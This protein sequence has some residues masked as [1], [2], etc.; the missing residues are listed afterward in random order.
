MPTT[1]EQA[2]CNALATWLRAQTALAD[3]EFLSHWPDDEGR[4]QPKTIAILRAGEPDREP[5][6]PVELSSENI[7]DALSARIVVA[8]PEDLP[9]AITALNTCRSSYEAHRVSTAAHQA[10]DTT[11]I[12]AAPAASN[13]S[14]AITLANELRSDI[15]LHEADATSH[16]NAD[17]RNRITAAAASDLA[18]LLTLTAAIVR[19]L[20]SHY[21]ARIFLWRVEALVQPVQMDVWATYEAVRDE[22]LAAL[23]PALHARARDTAPSLFPGPGLGG[24]D[25]VRFDLLLELGDGWTGCGATARFDRPVIADRPTGAQ[26]DEWR[27]T[28]AGEIECFLIIRSQSPRLTTIELKQY[29]GENFPSIDD[30]AAEVATIQQTT[31]DPGYSVTYSVE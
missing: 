7:H 10:A 25:P 6:D 11:H 3:V 9:T 21:V 29:V 14:T 13:L 31:A 22:M 15:N 16:A 26:A 19:A 27:A 4:L 24:D 30:V 2:A 1:I 17:T 23:D 18:T 20:N 5:V 8:T 28:F 12:I